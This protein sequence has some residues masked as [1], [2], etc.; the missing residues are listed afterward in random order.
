MSQGKKAEM[1][2]QRQKNPQKV[3][4]LKGSIACVNLAG[5]RDA[6]IADKTISGCVCEDVSRSSKQ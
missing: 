3:V 6:Q 2:M 5:L 4:T 1:W